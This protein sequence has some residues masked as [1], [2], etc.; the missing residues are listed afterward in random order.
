MLD[1]AFLAAG[2]AF[3]LLAIGYVAACARM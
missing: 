3:F 1:L 2:L